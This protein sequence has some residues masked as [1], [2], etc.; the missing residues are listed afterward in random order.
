MGDIENGPGTQ[1]PPSLRCWSLATFHTVSFVALAVVATHVNGSLKDALGR[2]D[3]ATGMAAFMVFWVLTFFSSRA[4]LR[5]MM[6]NDNAPTV[7]VVFQTTIAGGWN[8][9]GIFASLIVV[10]LVS[11]F[12]SRGVAAIGFLPVQFLVAVIGMLLAFAIGSI[13]GLA[14]GL[15][16]ALL[17]G[18]GEMLDRWARTCP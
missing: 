3:T 14:Y 2:L 8:G 16:D 18:C 6:P 17:L 10:S 13:I 1:S 7:S 4:G 12:A 11:G 15:I 5:K 9:T